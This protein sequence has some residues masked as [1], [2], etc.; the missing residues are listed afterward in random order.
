MKIIS[1]ME[2]RIKN[3]LE[4]QD[5][6]KLAKSSRELYGYALQHLQNFCE[7][8]K[9]TELAGFQDHMPAFAKYLENKKV[10]G[11]SIQRY[12]TIVK[13]FFKWAKE[14]LEY[15]YRLSNAETKANK[16]KALN[17]W[18]T[19]P[20]IDKCLG[21]GFEKCT[22]ETALRNRIMVRILI[23]TGARVRELA[24]VEAKDI[25]L[26]TGTILINNSKTEPR[27]V[28][29][30]SETL[31]MLE[32]YQ[33]GDKAL[34]KIA[35]SISSTVTA[36]VSTQEKNVFPAVNAIKGI[37]TEMLRD[38]KLKKPKDGR[39]GHCFRH[40][41]ATNLYYRGMKMSDIAILLGDKEDTIRDHYIHLTPTMLREK[42]VEV[43]GWEL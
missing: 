36:L 1:E 41:C 26:E 35:N 40:F 34:S 31:G 38:L 32:R 16:R 23:E 3:Y 20:D 33:V 18:F 2:A 27:P 17:R 37:I 43:M 10:S 19:E 29:V 30:S 4:S 8:K 39:G 9:I 7:L 13:L 5:A 24:S 15:T 14:P 28:F 11:K 22:P 21:Y 6:V 25:H 42:V 12:V